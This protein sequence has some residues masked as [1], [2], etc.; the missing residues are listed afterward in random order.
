MTLYNIWSKNIYEIQWEISSQKEENLG[1]TAYSEKLEFG[2]KMLRLNGI[3]YFFLLNL[4][5]HIFWWSY[6]AMRMRWISIW[7]GEVSIFI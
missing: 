3:M 4:M 1:R 5:M 7:K 2:K 6:L